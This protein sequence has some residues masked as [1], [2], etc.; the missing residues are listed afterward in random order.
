MK[1]IDLQNESIDFKF[2]LIGIFLLPAAPIIACLFFIYP[3]LKG[4]IDQRNIIF[5]DKL[6]HLLIASSLLMTLRC[7]FNIDIDD[8]NYLKTFQLINLTG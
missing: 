4:L 5:E 2:F 1:N 6:N 3:L 7:F 8:S